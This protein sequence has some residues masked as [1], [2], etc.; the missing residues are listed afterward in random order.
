MIYM[1]QI[2]QQR[3]W[4]PGDTGQTPIPSPLKSRLLVGALSLLVL[5]IGL[6]PEPLLS[7]SQD[8]ALVLTQGSP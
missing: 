4:V 8:A 5:A 2:Y 7:L 1:F 3:F 6:W